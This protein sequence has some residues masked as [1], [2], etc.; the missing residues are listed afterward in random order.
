MFSHTLAQI[1]DYKSLDT[2]FVNTVINKI[3]SS[4][5]ENTQAIII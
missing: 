3:S 1:F 2:T 4:V 5:I